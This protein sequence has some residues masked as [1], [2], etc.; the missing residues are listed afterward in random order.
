MRL[1]KGCLRRAASW[2]CVTV[3]A[4]SLGHYSMGHLVHVIHNP[5]AAAKGPEA[6]VA[7][8]NYQSSTLEPIIMYL[9][10]QSLIRNYPVVICYTHRKLQL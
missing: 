7:L 2:V 1:Q 6:F 9:T 4:G 8:L 10:N 5:K 3:L